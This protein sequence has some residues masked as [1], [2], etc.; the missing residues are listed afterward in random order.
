MITENKVLDKSTHDY[1]NYE[2]RVSWSAIIA[3]AF[4]GLGI[5]FLLYVFGAAI[6]LSSFTAT[7]KTLQRHEF[8]F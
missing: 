7:Q 3:G 5:S 2:K 1:Q 4:V 8:K 6:G